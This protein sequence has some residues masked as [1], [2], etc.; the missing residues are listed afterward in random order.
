MLR[1]VQN[2]LVA[3]IILGFPLSLVA[4]CTKYWCDHVNREV[5][6]PDDLIKCDVCGKSYY[7]A[8]WKFVTEWNSIE[9]HYHVLQCPNCCFMKF[10]FIR[11]HSSSAGYPYTPPVCFIATAAFGTPFTKEVK[12]LQEFKERYLL[13]NSLGK[14]FVSI[15][16]KISPPIAQFIA[17]NESRR[18]ITRTLLIP[19]VKMAKV[20]VSENVI[21]KGGPKIFEIASFL[22][23][24]LVVVLPVY[25][26]VSNVKRKKK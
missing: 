1:R 12:T 19:V 3:L 24:V 21:E 22:L 14:F 16:Y 10:V 2:I 26:V 20:A 6:C 5:A 4:E 7:L 8:Q 15:Y 18:R 25:R 11:R 23:L 13:C 17:K 9:A